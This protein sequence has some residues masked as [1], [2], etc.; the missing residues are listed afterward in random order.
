MYIPKG[1]LP[2]GQK[3]LYMSIQFS[4]N[5]GFLPGGNPRSIEIKV[6]DLYEINKDFRIEKAAFSDK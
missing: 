6:P 3:V 2:P 1:Q 5:E 4:E